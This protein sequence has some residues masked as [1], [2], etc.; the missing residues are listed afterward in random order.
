MLAYSTFKHSHHYHVNKC[1]DWTCLVSLIWLSIMYLE[2]LMLLLMLCCVILTLL[3][4]LGQ[5]SLVYWLRFM[6]LRQLL[7]M[8]HGN[9]SR[10]Q[11]VLVRVVLY[12]MMVCCATH[13]VGI[14]SVWWSLRMQGNEQTC[15]KVPQW[16]L[17]YNL[18]V[19]HRFVPYPNNIGEKDWML[20]L[21]NT[22]NSAWFARER[23]L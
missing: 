1:F 4:L 12:S 13:V 15:S 19:H 21:S 6:R 2:S 10:K 9:C 8:T 11:E 20:M 22:V 17:W 16:P 7:L 23:R 18:S 5:L 14:K 3:Q